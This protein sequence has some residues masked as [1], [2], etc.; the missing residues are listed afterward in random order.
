MQL[1]FLVLK[2]VDLCEAKAIM[3]TNVDIACEKGGVTKV[4]IN[5]V[6]CK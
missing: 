4:R 1:E 2:K 3:R 5:S 6:T